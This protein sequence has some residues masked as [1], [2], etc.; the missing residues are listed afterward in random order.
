MRYFHISL[1]L[2]MLFVANLFAGMQDEE[3]EYKSGDTVFKGY[4]VYEDEAIEKRPAVIV[5]H[6]WWGH[7][8]YAR[9]RAHMLAKL[10]YTALAI[11]M[12]GDGK[13]ADHPNDANAFMMEVIGN[14]EV[15]QN[16]FTAAYEFLK[17]HKSVDPERIAAIGYCFGGAVVLNMARTGMD[18]D[19][20]VSFHGDLTAKTKAEKD[21]VKTKILVCHGADDPF[22]PEPAIA[23]FKKEMEDAGVD[24]KFIAYEGAVHSFTNPGADKKGEE[25]NMPLAYNE[26]ADKESWAEMQSLFAE[27]FGE[28]EEEEEDMEE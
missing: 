15:M 26:K 23:A 18:L 8:D 5:V 4:I 22:V 25:F 6:E 21:K 11:D 20:V 28:V 16:R 9:K 14:F 24:Y 1:V 17:A 7:N 12:Y 19:A 2:V 10:G 3:V 13:Q 27:V